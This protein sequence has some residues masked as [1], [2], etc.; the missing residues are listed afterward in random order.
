MEFTLTTANRDLHSGIY[1]GKLLNAAQAMSQ[2]VE[3]LHTPDGKVAVKGFYDKVKPMTAEEKAMAA[4]APYDEQK[5]YRKTAPCCSPV[6]KAT[7]H[8]NGFGG[9][10]RST[11]PACGAAI[12]QKKVF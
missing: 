4:K 12:R 3:S 2:I 11:S 7:L 1:G 6:K 8:W 10:P 9:G 5:N